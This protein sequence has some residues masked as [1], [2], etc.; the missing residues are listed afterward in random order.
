MLL[1]SLQRTTQDQVGAALD[2]VLRRADDYLFDR[3]QNGEDVELTA[4]R[5]LRRARA[6]IVQRFDQ[7]LA[8]AFRKLQG[9]ALPRRHDP[10]PLSLLSEEGLEEQLAH[11]QLVN[12]L[13]HAHAPALELL[14]KRL[15]ALTGRVAMAQGE[16]P[17]APAFLGEA[18]HNA[19]GAVELPTGVRIVLYKFF[20]RELATALAGLYERLN[21]TLAAAGILPH[22]MPEVQAGAPP[23]EHES[24]PAQAGTGAREPR[25]QGRD[26]AGASDEAVYSELLDLLRVWKQGAAAAQPAGTPLDTR[27]V[28]SVLSLLQHEPPP[29]LEHAHEDDGLT[30]AERLRRGVLDGARRLGIGGE[31]LHL[32]SQADDAVDLV[33]MLFDVLLDERHFEPGVRRKLNRL[34]V[35]YVKVAMQ[36]RRMFLSREHPARRLLNVVAEACDG[37]HGDGPQE[38]ELLDRVDA[39]IDR[40]VAEYNE[41]MAIFELLEQELRA[42]LDQYRKRIELAERRAAEAQRG[43]ERLEQARESAAVDLALN[44]DARHLP[45]AVDEFVAQYASHHLTQVILREGKGS[46]RYADALRAVVGLMDACEDTGSVP[47]A[48][49]G[50]DRPVLLDVLASAGCSG[51]GAEEMLAALQRTLDLLAAGDRA[52]ADAVCLPAQAMPQPQPVIEPELRL[53]ADRRALDFDSDVA[54]RMR[55]L[56]VGT[57]VDLCDEAG[58]VEPVKVS[59]I[60]PI[61]SRLLFV[62]RRGL[63]A[64]VASPE[65]L[66]AMVKLGR[67][68]LREADTPF[69]TAMRR[70]MDR[71]K[72]RTASLHGVSTPARS[73]G[74]D[75]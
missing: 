21:A 41:D 10:T 68:R 49:A 32:S 40:L 17:A 44:R 50:L 28:I 8:G 62:N 24:A 25:P 63:R 35:P 69:D 34:L 9:P 29:G 27:S 47:D 61:S 74:T 65:E 12:S 3:S 13:A 22:A 71:M 51:P 73:G 39:A 72:A 53:V 48:D 55:A 57:W 26:E 66:A 56:E 1:A 16:N 37:N 52:A 70:M 38:R 43:R 42:F 54:E 20:E 19:L 59:W 2:L 18:L 4:L 5:D 23:A 11:E 60:S 33:G 31:G 64:L 36:D 67:L 46:P 30:L 58:S 15:A 14:D 6:G 7:A 75:A 45:P